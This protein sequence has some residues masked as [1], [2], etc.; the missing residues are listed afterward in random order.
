L[1]Q[2]GCCKTCTKKDNLSGDADCPKAFCTPCSCMV[3]ET[4]E[5]SIFPGLITGFCSSQS[6]DSLVPGTLS[7]SSAHPKHLVT[8]H[9]VL[10]SNLSFCR[11]KS[12]PTETTRRHQQE[13]LQGQESTCASCPACAH[14]L[15]KQSPLPFKK[16]VTP[17]TSNLPFQGRLRTRLDSLRCALDHA[18]TA[19]GKG[20]YAAWRKRTSRRHLLAGALA[21]LKGFTSLQ[22]EPNLRAEKPNSKAG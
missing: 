6:R 21:R 17:T 10:Q 9:E 3:E 4:T 2:S 8:L 5:G 1:R 16:A 18:T 7:P 19:T 11:N 13:I 12:G 14:R 15:S 22:A 20:A